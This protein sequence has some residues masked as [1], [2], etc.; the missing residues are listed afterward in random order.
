M[1]KTISSIIFE[2]ISDD[3]KKMYIA[4]SSRDYSNTVPANVIA[5]I[6]ELLSLEGTKYGVPCDV[7][8]D[9]LSVFDW[10]KDR[11]T[12]SDL[13]KMKTFLKQAVS[14]GF[15]KYCC[16]KV[17]TSGCANGMWAM[18]VPTTNGYSPDGGKTLYH[19]FTPDYSYYTVDLGGGFSEE[20]NTFREVKEYI[21]ENS[22]DIEDAKNT[23]P[24]EVT[25]GTED[26][27][28]QIDLVG[29]TISEAVQTLNELTGLQYNT[30]KLNSRQFKLFASTDNYVVVTVD[31]DKITNVSDINIKK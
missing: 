11:L 6:D 30:T 7:A 10:F 26:I 27:S 16:F 13:R 25:T 5:K 31:N 3:N 8:S 21:K 24:T 4:E 15:D 28:N 12:V 1:K 17:G 2:S 19:S 20:I 9:T 29:K 22:K 14:L 18:D 23:T